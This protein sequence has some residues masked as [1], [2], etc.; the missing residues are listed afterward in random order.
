M[1]LVG[2][3]TL[4]LRRNRNARLT[5]T[6]PH[7]AGANGVTKAPVRRQLDLTVGVIF[8]FQHAQRGHGTR[9]APCFA[10]WNLVWSGRE[11]GRVSRNQ[12]SAQCQVGPARP[13]IYRLRRPLPSCQTIGNTA[14]RRPRKLELSSPRIKKYICMGKVQNA[15]VLYVLYELGLPSRLHAAAH[16]FSCQ[17]DNMVHC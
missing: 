4:H 11:R 3:A 17:Q 15:S 8:R 1:M 16:L 10:T 9:F 2:G 7:R 14:E 12:K 6:A 5:K 13:Q